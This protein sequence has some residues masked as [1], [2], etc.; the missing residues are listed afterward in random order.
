MP[1][2]ALAALPGSGAIGLTLP[3][4]RDGQLTGAPA[5]HSRGAAAGHPGYPAWRESHP[6]SAGHICYE[7]Q[8]LLHAICA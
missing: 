3:C 8:A 2:T 1:E 6:E 5:A 7:D 4:R